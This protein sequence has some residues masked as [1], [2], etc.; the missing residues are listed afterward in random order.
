MSASVAV[1]PPQAG[2]P[3]AVV[4]GDGDSLAN[5]PPDPIEQAF[6]QHGAILIRGFPADLDAFRAV[7]DRLCSTW[8]INEATQ[9]RMIDA[10]SNIQSVNTGT[11]PFPLH[12]E[13]SRS[14]WRPDACLFYCIDP[15]QTGGE[16]T[17]C[18]GV[19]LAAALPAE[20][21]AK[22]AGRRLLFTRRADA[23][24]IEKWLGVKVPTPDLIRFPPADCPYTFAWHSGYL[25]MNFSRPILQKPMFTDAP[26]FANFLLFARDMRQNRTQPVL[27]D[28]SIIP[29]EWVDIIRAASDRLT[30]AIRWRPGD[31]L[32]L[33]NSR[34]MHGRRRVAEDGP[35]NIAS[36]F[37]YLRCAPVNPEEPVDPIWRRA[38][39]TPPPLRAM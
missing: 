2:R 16:T 23:R 10:A 36:R 34:F 25:T 37:G 14:P 39:F 18:D 11:R 22:L 28:G 20:L 1:D 31:L 24:A 5:L 19:A 29:D 12:S 7:S 27:D 3:Y 33:D 8:V 30:A 38:N 6:K 4:T 32:L 26:A 13:I 17:I 9:R 35:R 15:P 21:T